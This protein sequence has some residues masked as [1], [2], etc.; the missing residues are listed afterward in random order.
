MTLVE[1]VGSVLKLSHIKNH[2]DGGSPT[3]CRVI[4][5]GHSQWCP[6]LIRSQDEWYQPQYTTWYQKIGLDK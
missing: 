3:Q 4:R 2:T 1:K 5:R 6:N